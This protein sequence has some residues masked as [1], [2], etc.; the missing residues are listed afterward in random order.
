MHKETCNKFRLFSLFLFIA[1]FLIN[2]G[3]YSEDVYVS[4]RTSSQARIK[5]VV[6]VSFRASLSPGD[7]PDIVRDPLSG[8]TY[9]AEPVTQQV[10]DKMT[11]LLFNRLKAAEMYELISPGQAMGVI[12]SIIDSDSTLGM[13]TVKLMQQLGKSFDA[14]AVLTGYIYRWRE[15]EGGDYAVSEPA[16]VAFD[17]H[18]I[19]P[20]DGSTIWRGKF[21]KTQHSLSE[22]LLDF[23][24]FRKSGGKWMTAEKLAAVGLR[25]MMDKMPSD[26]KK[27]KE[28]GQINIPESVRLPGEVNSSSFPNS[29]RG[30]E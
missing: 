15:R 11:T 3:C 20:L 7:K 19:S 22:N 16:S 24:T 13:D 14:D 25:D 8:A 26:R 18:F 28:R 12:S 5:K 29:V 2:W 9:M 1:G 27:G 4:N 6:V 17:L 23:K 10:I 21:D 30:Q